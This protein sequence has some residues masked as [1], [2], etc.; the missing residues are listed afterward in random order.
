MALTINGSALVAMGG[1]RCVALASDRRFG[2]QQQTVAVDF[3]RVFKVN[4]RVL[5]GMSGLVTDVHT[6]REELMRKVQLYK[7]REDR[8]MK[9]STFDSVVSNF[10]YS[11]RFG[12][13]FV[14]PL[15]AGLEGKDFKPYI[16][17][18]DVLG[19]PVA[20]DDFVVAGS[21]DHS[22]YGMCEQLYRPN[23]NPDELFEVVAQCVI[24]AQDRDCLSGFGAMVYILTPDRL[25]MREV[26]GRHD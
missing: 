4:N 6:V 26:A 9:P 25:I 5:L 24:Q 23:L 10:L 11:R 14:E 15:I 22:L 18:Q 16:S 13:Y 12:P 19:C 20:T 8:E 21:A 17:G 1:D 7:L 3:E 2:V